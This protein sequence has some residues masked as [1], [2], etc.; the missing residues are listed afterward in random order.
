MEH[1]APKKAGLR[2]EKSIYPR[3]I[4]GSQGFLIY[5]MPQRDGKASRIGQPASFPAPF[6]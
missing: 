4:L 5:W 2:T 3:V 6:P 1:F